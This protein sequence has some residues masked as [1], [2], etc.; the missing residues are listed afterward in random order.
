MDPKT[1][2]QQRP[3]EL[4]DSVRSRAAIGLVVLA[5][6]HVIEHEF[7]KILNLP[8]VGLYQ[9]RILNEPSINAETLSAM[10]NRLE[11]SVRVILPGM[12][13][14][15][16]AYGCTSASMVIGPPRVKALCQNAK[17]GVRVTNPFTAAVEALREL[18]V[19]RMAL[20]TPY[21]DELNLQM[22][23]L[24]E[25]EGIEVPAM[26]SNRDSMYSPHRMGG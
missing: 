12:P 8:G 14:D 18:A 3:Y 26:A 10:E 23:G 6:D 7:R 22:R 15:V 1:S 2:L 25:K 16:I 21:R 19:S 24:F 11:D 4:D 5:T 20:L 13:L 17:P 9:S